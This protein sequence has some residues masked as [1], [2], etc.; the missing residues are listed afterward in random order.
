MT[1]E[2]HG[3]ELSYYLLSPVSCASFREFVIHIHGMEM[4]PLMH[5]HGFR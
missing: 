1:A 5:P 2:V 3:T 4:L